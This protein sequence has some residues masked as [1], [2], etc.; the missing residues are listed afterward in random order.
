LIEGLMALSMVSNQVSKPDMTMKGH[1]DFEGHRKGIDDLP[2]MT[3][4]RDVPFLL[5]RSILPLMPAWKPG[6]MFAPT[7]TELGVALPLKDNTS[8]LPWNRD[9]D[10]AVNSF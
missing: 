3:D 6:S 10:G 2:E 8:N 5:A 7:G 4:G 9:V 1:R